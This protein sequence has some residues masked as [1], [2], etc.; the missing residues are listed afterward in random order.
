MS[1]ATPKTIAILANIATSQYQGDWDVVGIAVWRWDVAED[2]QDDAVL[3]AAVKDKLA[4]AYYEPDPEDNSVALTKLGWNLLLDDHGIQISGDAEVDYKAF[5]KAHKARQAD[6]EA[7][8]EA[9]VAKVVKVPVDLEKK[10][11]VS[12]EVKCCPK[13]GTSG[14][15][16]ALFGYR[17]TKR[18][19]KDGTVVHTV[20]I[21]SYCR[22]CRSS[23]TKK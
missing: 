11:V 7:K 3:D 6:V 8:V 2:G 4:E 20:R 23:K 1:L 18:T 9:E 13:C 19:K 5:L 16:E 15:I 22:P 10:V 17:N 14:G 21:Q 12:P